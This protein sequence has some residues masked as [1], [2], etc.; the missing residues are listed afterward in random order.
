MR[1]YGVHNMDYIRA[2]DIL[3]P[4][5]IEQLQQYVDGA[6]IYIPKKEE[7]KRAWGERTATK[8]ELARRNAKIYTDFQAGK[9]IKE[10]AEEY[11]L[12]DKSIQ[13]I[14][15]QEKQKITRDRRN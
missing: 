14:I 15:R 8:K 9:S 11:F 1:H 13:R 4:E 12:A 7:D 3:P 5:L 10:L 2:V 6:V